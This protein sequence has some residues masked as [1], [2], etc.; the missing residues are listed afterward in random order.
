MPTLNVKTGDSLT[1]DQKLRRTLG[2][3]A[4]SQRAYRNWS[5][6]KRNLLGSAVL[7]ELQRAV[8]SRPFLGEIVLAVNVRYL[9]ACQH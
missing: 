5:G 3:L 4:D 9:P 1:E 7:L 6:N 2:C 8:R